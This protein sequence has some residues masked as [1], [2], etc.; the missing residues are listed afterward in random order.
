M[1]ATNAADQFRLDL[2]DVIANLVNAEEHLRVAL[3][4]FVQWARTDYELGIIEE[5]IRAR[6]EIR[7]AQDKLLDSHPNKRVK[8]GE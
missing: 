6:Q 5:T 3:I 4:R 7:R 2:E 1:G 8:K